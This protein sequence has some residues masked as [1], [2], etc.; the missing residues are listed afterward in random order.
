[1][2]QPQQQQQQQQHQIQD[3]SGTYATVWG[4]TRSLSHWMGPGVKPASS[5]WR[6]HWVLNPLS[7]HGNSPDSPFLFTIFFSGVY[8]VPV[9]GMVF[10]VA[11]WHLSPASLLL[12]VP[13]VTSVVAPNS[14]ERLATSLETLCQPFGNS[15]ISAAKFHIPQGSWGLLLVCTFSGQLLSFQGTFMFLWEVKTL[16]VKVT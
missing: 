15:S 16:R 1:M 3:T 12:W 7:H 8:Q 13:A 6:Q 4:T 10:L 9:L 2:P 5:A 11:L 14:W